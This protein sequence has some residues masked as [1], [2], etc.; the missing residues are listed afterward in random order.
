[1][2]SRNF[3]LSSLDLL[4]VA[5]LQQFFFFQGWCSSKVKLR[6]I[7][8]KMCMSCNKSRLKMID[9]VSTQPLL[10]FSI[11]REFRLNKCTWKLN[12]WLSSADVTTLWGPGLIQEKTFLMGNPA[13]EPVAPQQKGRRLSTQKWSN[14]RVHMFFPPRRV[15]HFWTFFAM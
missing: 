6:L 12:C 13:N 11:F 2:L 15:L 9:G 7:Q 5:T 10:R 14:L 8:Q 1:M 4:I 3:G